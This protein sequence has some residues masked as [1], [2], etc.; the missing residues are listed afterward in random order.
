MIFCMK[1]KKWNIVKKELD[2]HLNILYISLI[3]DVVDFLI[4]QETENVLH[5]KAVIKIRDGSADALEDEVK[6]A[7]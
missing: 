5:Y 1:E 4:K 2:R 7:V 6:D 3:L